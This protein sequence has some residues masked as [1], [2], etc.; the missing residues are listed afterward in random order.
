MRRD[1]LEP[2]VLSVKEAAK[3]PGISR[4]Q[5]SG[6][7]NG[8]AGISAEMAIRFD[9]AFGGG[10]STWYRL[11]AAYDLSPPSNFFPLRHG[12]LRTRLGNLLLPAAVTRGKGEILKQRLRGLP[13]HAGVRDAL[14]EGQ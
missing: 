10:A 5:L 7:V 6:I 2:L 1:C 11:Q 12:R 13:R 14:S 8:H 4:K 3:R 9:K